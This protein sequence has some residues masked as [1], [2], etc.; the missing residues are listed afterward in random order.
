M[1][2]VIDTLWIKFSTINIFF[3]TSA[4]VSSGV[5]LQDNRSLEL[6]FILFNFIYLFILGCRKPTEIQRA[7][8]L[9]LL[10][11]ENKNTCTYN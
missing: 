6:V 2:L 11:L 3:L 10:H 7:V 9:E 1:L 5:H 8:V 4:S